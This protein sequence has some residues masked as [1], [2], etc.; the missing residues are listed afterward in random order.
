M[1]LLAYFLPHVVKAV[2]QDIGLPQRQDRRLRLLLPAFAAVVLTAIGSKRWA[3]R[4]AALTR[5]LEAGRNL[6]PVKPPHPNDTTHYDS[7]EL[8]GLPARAAQRL[9]ICLSGC[10]TQ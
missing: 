6:G 5:E 1:L 7:H 9:V 8:E 2:S 4:M 3:E 10:P